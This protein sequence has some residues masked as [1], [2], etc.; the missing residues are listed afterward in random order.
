MPGVTTDDVA[1]TSDI[2]DKVEA[3]Y[4]ID[5]Q[6][7]FGTGKS[8]GGNMVDILACHNAMSK[9]VA[10]YAPVSGSFYVKDF[11][12]VC[13]PDTVN[14][15]PCDPGRKNIPIISFHGKADATISY[16]GGD[17]RGACLPSIPHWAQVWAERDGLGADNTTSRLAG[18]DNNDAVVYRWGA[19]DAKGMVTHVMDGDVSPKRTAGLSLLLRVVLFPY[20]Y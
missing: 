17:R 11:G 19:G 5:T 12:D 13:R 2:L 15:G 9:R 16:Y 10:A 1:F 20:V 4:C 3:E 8:Q 7:I 14:T 6:R 18:A